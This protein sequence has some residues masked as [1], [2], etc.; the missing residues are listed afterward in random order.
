TTRQ[1]ARAVPV[2]GGILSPDGK[3]LAGSVG[4]EVKVWDAQTG[5]EILTLTEHAGR[6]QGVAFSPDGRRLVSAAA[7]RTV[8]LWDAQ[9]GEE[10]R[11][12]KG[13]SG[14]V[15]DRDSARGGRG[16]VAV[17]VFSPD[18]RRVA[19]GNN[20]GVGTGPRTAWTTELKV[21]D[22]QTGRE[23]VTYKG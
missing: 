9:T 22:A 10:L 6:V 11:P 23:V 2:P 5:R 13:L 15:N 4:N 19:S 12:F 16:P 18:G 3:H 21:W 17:S 14:P 20:V 7:D 8:K 1:E